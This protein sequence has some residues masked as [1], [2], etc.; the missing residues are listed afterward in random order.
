VNTQT[1]TQQPNYAP[2]PSPVADL[3]RQH[4]VLMRAIWDRH[5]REQQGPSQERPA[6]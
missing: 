4:R 6:A 2:R 5:A 1:R 3:I